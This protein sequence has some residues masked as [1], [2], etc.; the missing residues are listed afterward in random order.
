MP[1]DMPLGAMT[2]KREKAP[3]FMVW[4]H[5]GDTVSPH[6]V[7]QAIIGSQH[8]AVAS[9]TDVCGRIG[10]LGR[11]AGYHD[12]GEVNLHGFWVSSKTT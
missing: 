9:P 5:Q 7:C 10:A 4:S 11:T 2:S 1:G 8:E 12:A 3:G 6:R